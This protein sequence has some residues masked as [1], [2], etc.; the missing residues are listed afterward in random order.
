MK[1][2]RKFRLNEWILKF[3]IECRRFVK[4]E[5]TGPYEILKYHNVC[6]F[7]YYEVTDNMGYL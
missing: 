6:E 4:L 7:F 1:L 2:K 5:N 3:I